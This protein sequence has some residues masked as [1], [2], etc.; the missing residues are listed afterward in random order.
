LEAKKLVF[1]SL[2]LETGGENCG[3]IH[4]LA[5]IVRLEINRI[6]DKAAKDMLSS[7]VQGSGVYHEGENSPSTIFNKYVNPGKD[8]EWVPAVVAKVL[9]GLSKSDP[10]ILSAHSIDAV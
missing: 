7:V 1:I 8:A 10:R 4:I 3:I 6:E 9:H 2:D 5:E